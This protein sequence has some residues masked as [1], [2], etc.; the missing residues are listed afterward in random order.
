MSDLTLA[1]LS[2][3]VVEPSQMQRRIITD[4]LY[5]AGIVNISEVE[6]G[7]HALERIAF[8]DI[9]L[10]VSGEVTRV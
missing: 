6:Q 9:D 2:V 7:E 5:Q 10:I 1:N 3:L 4:A 8:G